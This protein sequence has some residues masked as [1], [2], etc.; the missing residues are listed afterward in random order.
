MGAGVG[1]AVVGAAVGGGVLT[2]VDMNRRPTLR[3]S[4]WHWTLFAHKREFVILGQSM[5]GELVGAVGEF[6]GAAVGLLVGR[7]VG[8]LVGLLVGCFVGLCDGRRVGRNVGA[9]VGRNVGGTVGS[10]VGKKVGEEVKMSNS[11][12]LLHLNGPSP[13]FE[14]AA[15]SWRLTVHCPLTLVVI[16]PQT[17]S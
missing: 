4:T 6:V 11:L 14:E 1:A 8:L 7:L 2:Q 17:C 15:M 9:V 16:S 5:V 13:L 3:L 12:L 10:S